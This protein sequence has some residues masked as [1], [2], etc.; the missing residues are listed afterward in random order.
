MSSLSKGIILVVIAL[1]ALVQ[2]ALLLIFLAPATVYYIWTYHDR[3]KELERR[4]NALGK[5][6]GDS[7]L[8]V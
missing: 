2:P 6:P 7:D 4:V 8:P 3:I 1:L 5:P